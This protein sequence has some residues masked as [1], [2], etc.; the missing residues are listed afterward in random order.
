MMS[1]GFIGRVVVVAAASW[2]VSGASAAAQMPLLIGEILM[3]DHGNR[4]TTAKGTYV[5][6]DGAGRW[7]RLRPNSSGHAPRDANMTDVLKFAA[8]DL[9]VPF[10]SGR[11]LSA[12]DYRPQSAAWLGS[13]IWG[14]ADGARDRR[15]SKRKVAGSN[16]VYIRSSAERSRSATT[17]PR[18]PAH[19][20]ASR[21]VAGMG[22]GGQIYGLLVRGPRYVLNAAKFFY[23]GKDALIYG[24][25][26][27]FLMFGLATTLDL[28]ARTRRI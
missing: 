11:K 10:A 25:G 14:Y 15:T 19:A 18:A 5:A 8:A 20:T 4:E 23:R 22:D 3:S 21:S 26:L 1:N 6:V 24:I 16:A 27:I 28:V 2:V 13:R 17:A 7:L 12:M 9:V